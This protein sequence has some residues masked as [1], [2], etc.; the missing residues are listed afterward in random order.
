MSPIFILIIIF[1]WTGGI[2]AE[3]KMDLSGKNIERMVAD[4]VVKVV[5]ESKTA[6]ELSRYTVRLDDGTKVLLTTHI[7]PKFSYGTKLKVSGEIR[8]AP[9]FENFNYRAYLRKEGIDAIMYMPKIRVEDEGE[10]S[11]A[12]LMYS[13]KDSLR[14][15]LHSSLPYPHNTIAGAMILGDGDRVPEEIGSLFSSTGIRHIIAISGMHVTII[16]GIILVLFSS[17][18]SHNRSISFYAVSLLIV[19]FVFFVGAPA[20]AVRAGIMAIIFLFA[21]KTGKIYDAPRA[22][23]IAGVLMLAINPLLLV[24]DIGFQLS[25]LAVF[26]ILYLT[27]HF[28]RILGRNESFLTSENTLS[29]LKDGLISLLSVSLGAHLATLPIVAYNF[30]IISFSAPMANLIA[31]PLL[32]VV[33]ISSFSAAFSGMFVSFLGSLFALPALM[34]L[35]VIL[36]SARLL[37]ALPM[38]SLELEIH[39]IWVVATYIIIIS[40]LAFP[41]FKNY[42]FK[43]TNPLSVPAPR[44]ENKP[45]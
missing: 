44:Q 23:F 26:G 8:K 19:I 29:S 27:P 31:V 15:S 5:S 16:A 4:E 22:L 20:S 12:S 14:T 11:V 2:Y 9:V 33:I 30:G 38:S 40:L 10:R 21:F 1:L 45:F 41:N 17:L 7:Y 24:Y 6:G 35:E 25:F 42:L 13:V 18:I 32:P 43:P 39:V 28:E 34:A 3:S 37:D 36:Q